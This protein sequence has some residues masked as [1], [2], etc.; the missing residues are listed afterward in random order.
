ME[1]VV[2]TKSKHKKEAKIEENLYKEKKNHSEKKKKLETEE[3]KNNE[4]K[5]IADIKDEKDKKVISNSQGMTSIILTK[6]GQT[7]PTPSPVKDVLSNRDAV[8]VYFMKHY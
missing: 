5:H 7:K 8:I 3:G 2:D 4:N 6:P 1:K